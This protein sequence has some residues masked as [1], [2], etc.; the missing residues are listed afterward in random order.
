MQFCLEK[1]GEP[2]KAHLNGLLATVGIVAAL[3]ASF[4]IAGIPL[5]Y[6]YH[7]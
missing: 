6:A 2:M 3:V 7:T 4:I 5:V 1:G